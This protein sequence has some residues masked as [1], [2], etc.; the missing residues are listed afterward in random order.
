MKEILDIQV[1]S[2]K[3]Q[4]IKIMSQVYVPKVAH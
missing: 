1:N 2:D 3:K 4:D